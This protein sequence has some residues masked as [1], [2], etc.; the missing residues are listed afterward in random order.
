MKA[1]GAPNKSSLVLG[2]FERAGGDAASTV[3]VCM[4]GGG[5]REQV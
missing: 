3:C 1:K 2:E 5:G 4:C